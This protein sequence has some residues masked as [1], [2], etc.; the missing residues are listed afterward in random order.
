MA[1]GQAKRNHARALTLV[2]TIYATLLQET[3]DHGVRKLFAAKCIAPIGDAFRHRISAVY[4]HP[5]C[6]SIVQEYLCCLRLITRGSSRA[7][8]RGDEVHCS[9]FPPARHERGLTASGH[10]A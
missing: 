8:T 2:F 5:W 1:H 6:A 9:R 3:K 4:L 10:D 7:F